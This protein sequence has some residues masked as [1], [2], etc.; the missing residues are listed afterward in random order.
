MEMQITLQK[1]YVPK[2]LC[3]RVLNSQYPMFPY[4]VFCLHT[5]HLHCGQNLHSN[6]NPGNIGQLENIGST[7]C[8]VPKM[9][10]KNQRNTGS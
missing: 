6:S 7:L 5:V 2:A 3:C 10:H 1:S 9:C 8:H 4:L